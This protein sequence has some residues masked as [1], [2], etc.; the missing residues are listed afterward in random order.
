MGDSDFTER[1]LLL[2]IR[3]DVQTMKQQITQLSQE[4]HVLK[5][6]FHDAEL[7]RAQT[8]VSKAEV[9]TVHNEVRTLQL[10][11]ATFETEAKL[12]LGIVSA[13]GGMIA[14]AL[15]TMLLRLFLS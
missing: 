4:Q 8:A 9:E 6:R 3:A 12:K 1:E 10:R 11:F 7:T 5:Q 15:T 13:F 2:L 14:S